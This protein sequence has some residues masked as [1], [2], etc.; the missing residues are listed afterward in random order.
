M[1]SAP[2]GVE[3]LPVDDPQLVPRSLEGS[4]VQMV[5]ELARM[6]VV[7]RAFDAAMRTLQAE[8]AAS[9]RLLQEI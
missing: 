5:A 9:S 4:N 8:D 1:L 3:A 7:Q 6:V 2:D